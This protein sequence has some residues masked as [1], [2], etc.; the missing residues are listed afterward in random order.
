MLKFDSISL[1]KGLDGHGGTV[2]VDQT[3]WNLFSTVLVLD[4]VPCKIEKDLPAGDGLNW[5]CVNLSGKGM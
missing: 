2:P 5:H 1:T 3:F 4:S